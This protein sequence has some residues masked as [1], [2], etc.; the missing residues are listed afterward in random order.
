MF[1]LPHISL[2]MPPSTCDL[3]R[4]L[5]TIRAC[6][7][8][9]SDGL[10]KTGLDD[11]IFQVSDDEGDT[12]ADD[13]DDD[14]LFVPT[15]GIELVTSAK[16]VVQ[17]TCTIAYHSALLRLAAHAP[18]Q[19]CSVGDCCQ[20]LHVDTAQHGTALY[21]TWVCTIMVE[22]SLQSMCQCIMFIF[23]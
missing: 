9:C 1:L 22:Q 6:F 8:H 12:A 14:L 3:W 20:P 19:N 2:Y 7:S 5:K 17:E 4:T 18:R 10:E 11:T 23:G 15:S 16:D 13:S 21:L